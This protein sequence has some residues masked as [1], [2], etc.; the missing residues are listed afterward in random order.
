MLYTIVY[1]HE[2]CSDIYSETYESI[3]AAILK[4]N[5]QFTVCSLLAP[6]VAVRTSG[7]PSSA[8][9]LPSVKMWQY[10]TDYS[11]AYGPFSGEQMQAWVQQ[12]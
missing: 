9:T 10:K 4:E 11:E 1:V 5:P 7:A 8:S 3:L 12:V 2:L 6:S